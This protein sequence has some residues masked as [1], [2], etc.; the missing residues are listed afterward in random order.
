MVSSYQNTQQD[1]LSGKRRNTLLHN[2]ELLR[3]ELSGLDFLLQQEITVASSQAS[4]INFEMESLTTELRRLV[5]LTRKV[6]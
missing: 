4:V 3:V 5:T 2:M 1:K 6:R